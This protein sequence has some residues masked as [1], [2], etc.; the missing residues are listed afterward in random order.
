MV[1]VLLACGPSTEIT[2]S[3]KSEKKP[4]K[5]I[6]SVM[7]A[8]L[9]SNIN[10]RQTLEN[11]LAKRLRESGVN[12]VKSMDVLPPTYT[13]TGA[14]DKEE[15]L[16]KIKDNHVDAILTVAL[17]DEQTENR[18][19][20]GTYGYAPL[21]SFGYYG[22]FSGYFNTW[23]PVMISPGYYVMDRI[24]FLETNLYDAETE[25]LI[26]SAQ[27]ETYN[28]ANLDRFSEGYSKVVIERM[29]EDGAI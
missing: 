13:E 7:V 2:G 27:S 3:W 14:V 20:P 5:I 18:Y 26:W 9:T 16:K 25:E 24:Y 19:V 21:S 6:T 8:A 11:D 28:P 23:Y 22:Y 10:A 29:K 1:V 17:V 4:E 12:V 15:L